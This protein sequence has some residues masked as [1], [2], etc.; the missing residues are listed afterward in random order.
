MSIGLAQ[1]TTPYMSERLKKL[2]AQADVRTLSAEIE[3]LKASRTN[4]QAEIATLTKGA[5]ALRQDVARLEKRRAELEKANKAAMAAF[6]VADRKRRAAEHAISREALEERYA[7]LTD[8]K[9]RAVF[10][11]RYAKEL[12]LKVAR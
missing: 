8:P 10:R 12:G 1:N 11:R 3:K 2:L 6:T 5:E 4:L 7:K 9:A